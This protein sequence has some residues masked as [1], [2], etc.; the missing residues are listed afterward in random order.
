MLEPYQIELIGRKLKNN[1]IQNNTN[2]L[3]DIQNEKIQLFETAVKKQTDIMID[4]IL[5]MGIDVHL[6]GLRQAARE[7]AIACPIFEDDSFRIAN[8]FALSTSQVS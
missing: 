4:N 2:F 7:N 1:I 6:L 3:C 8:H 5:G